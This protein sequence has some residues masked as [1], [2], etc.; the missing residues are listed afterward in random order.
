MDQMELQERMAL[1]TKGQVT[2]AD[3]SKG[4]KCTMCSH[5]QNAPPSELSLSR[6]DLKN[7]C[8]LV[9]LHTK[10]K[11]ALFNGKTA[12]ACSMFSM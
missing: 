11:G 1:T 5:L 4:M 2:W 7:R 12:I 9:K 8:A 10:K 6:R 3:P